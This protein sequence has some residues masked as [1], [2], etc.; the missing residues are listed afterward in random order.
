MSKSPRSPARTDASS[1]ANISYFPN[2][3]LAK[4]IVKAWSDKT[5]EGEL[6]TFGHDA[7]VNWTDLTKDQINPMLVKTSGALAQ[8]DVY[9]D[10]AVVLT[11]EQYA[12]FVDQYATS[13]EQLAQF[14]FV[15]PDPVGRA[16]S[17]ATA[18]VAM[19]VHPCGI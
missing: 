9:L 12:S 2:D 15:L 18:Q 5:F 6:L 10:S 14:I 1:W 7:V 13:R 19:A 16:P 11:V 3:N 4:A 8:V 17:L